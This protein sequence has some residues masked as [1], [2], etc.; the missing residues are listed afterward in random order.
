MQKRLYLQLIKPL[1]EQQRL[2][3]T[4]RQY[5]QRHKP[6]PLLTLAIK[7]PNRLHLIKRAQ[8][9][10]IPLFITTCQ[11]RFLTRPPNIKSQ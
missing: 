10:M 11:F 9:P 2:Q 3:G 5:N 8:H 1:Q 7:Q 4:T 6:T